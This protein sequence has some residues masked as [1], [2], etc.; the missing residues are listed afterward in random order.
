MGGKRAHVFDEL[1]EVP[2]GWSIGRCDE[3]GR[4]EQEPEMEIGASSP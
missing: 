4:G 1:Q 3:M 2:H